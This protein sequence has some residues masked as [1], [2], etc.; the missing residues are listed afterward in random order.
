MLHRACPTARNIVVS[1]SRQCLHRSVSLDGGGA[2]GFAVAL[3][4]M[5][6]STAIFLQAL[7]DCTSH[8]KQSSRRCMH[9]QFGS[10][11]RWW[12]QSKNACKHLGLT[13]LA[14]ATSTG[15]AVQCMASDSQTITEKV[16]SMY[17]PASML[18]LYA[19]ATMH[20]SCIGCLLMHIVH[21][22]LRHPEC[23]DI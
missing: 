7:V 22:S 18:L 15:L 16:Y 19:S 5:I 6:C 8:L 21:G 13:S 4:S 17:A 3:L 9:T 11:S 10:S 14:V 20:L 12:Q 1:S 23:C 2:L